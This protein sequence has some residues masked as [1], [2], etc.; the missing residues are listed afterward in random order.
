MWERSGVVI[1]MQIWV[2]GKRCYDKKPVM[3]RLYSSI[4][5]YEM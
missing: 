1:I 4:R 2:E 5:W 3:E